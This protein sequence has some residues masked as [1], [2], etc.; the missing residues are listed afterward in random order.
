MS[1]KPYRFRG[2]K[3]LKREMFLSD[4][5]T[6]IVF[7][8]IF[9]VITFGFL[10]VVFMGVFNDSPDKIEIIV[11]A[12]FPALII[13][14]IAAFYFIKESHISGCGS[15]NGDEE[16]NDK[17]WGWRGDIDTGNYFR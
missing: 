11:F 1:K 10:F 7:F 13:G 8:L 9:S 12:G 3:E 16:E 15:S 4:L 5:I 2:V 6:G 17:G 14:C